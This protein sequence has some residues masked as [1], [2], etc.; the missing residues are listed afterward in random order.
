MADSR[1]VTYCEK[2]HGKVTKEV[3]ADNTATACEELSYFIIE[4]F[5]VYTFEQ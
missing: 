2:V 5:K 4:Q 1:V 3:V